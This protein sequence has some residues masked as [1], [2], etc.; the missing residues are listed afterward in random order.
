MEQTKAETDKKPGMQNEN[1][2]LEEMYPIYIS[3]LFLLQ[4]SVL[5]FDLSVGS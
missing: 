5:C 1:T 4:F 3:P 2:V